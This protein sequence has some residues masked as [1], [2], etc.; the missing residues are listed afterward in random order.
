MDILQ[1]PGASNYGGPGNINYFMI[2][3]LLCAAAHG[4]T[5]DGQTIHFPVVKYVIYA[6]GGQERGLF[7]TLDD[8]ADYLAS[9]AMVDDEGLAS[10]LSTLLNNYHA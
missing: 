5:L 7:D 9:N 2:E 3:T 4:Q 8:F 1:N 10:E 6:V